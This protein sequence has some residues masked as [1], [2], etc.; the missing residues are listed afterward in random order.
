[1]LVKLRFQ[2]PEVV[3]GI[4]FSVALFALG[5]MFVSSRQSPSSEHS[6]QSEQQ[7]DHKGETYHKETQS[8]WVPVDSVGLYTLVLAIFTGVL[9]SVSIFQGVMLLR[10]DK[11]ANIT[12]ESSK[13]SA[14]ATLEQVKT[15]RNI[16]RAELQV[17][18][19]ETVIDHAPASV[20]TAFRIA[21]RWKNYGQTPAI[22]AGLQIDWRN[23]APNQEPV[24]DSPTP[25]RSGSIGSGGGFKTGYVVIP[26]AIASRAWRR[27]LRIFIF[28][29]ATYRDIFDDTQDRISNSVS[30]VLFG[31][32]PTIFMTADDRTTLMQIG[33]YGGPYRFNP[34]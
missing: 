29:N 7:T 31:A 10:A 15:F 18:G 32:D 12:A 24:F 6:S 23:V 2:F 20:V 5:A 16:Q 9:A 11:T 1:M 19:F 14:A 17:E 34:V 28:T 30:E 13:I 22:M 33:G 4:L 25:V 26:V 27:E 21:A 3:I 8:L